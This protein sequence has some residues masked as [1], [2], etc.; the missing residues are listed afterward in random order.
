[1]VRPHKPVEDLR[2]N[3]VAVMLSD[4]ELESIDNWRFQ[5]RVGSRGGAMRRMCEIAMK[6][7]ATTAKGI[8]E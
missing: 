6:V 5:N 2:N 8:S 7:A 1:M 3:R 4:D